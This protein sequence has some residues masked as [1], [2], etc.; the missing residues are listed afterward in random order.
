MM[1]SKQLK[2]YF[3]SF[4]LIL[5]LFFT[6]CIKNNAQNRVQLRAE[7]NQIEGSIFAEWGSSQSSLKKSSLN[8]CTGQ[9]VVLFILD[10]KGEKTD[11]ISKTSLQNDG[12]FLFKNIKFTPRDL[13]SEKKYLLEFNCGSNR[14]VRFVTGKKQQNLSQGTALLSWLFQTNLS[15]DKLISQDAKT[16]ASLYKPLEEIINFSEAYS[17]LNSD[18]SLKAGFEKHFG[19]QPK[20]L[21]DAIPEIQNIKVPEAL[22]EEETSI[23]SVQAFHWSP[24]Y[25]FGYEWRI[26]SVTL[27]NSANFSFSPGANSQGS[28][29]IHLYAGK[30]NGNGG[31]DFSKPYWYKAFPVNINNTIPPSSP[32]VSRVSQEFTSSPTFTVKLDTGSVVDNLPYNCRSFSNFAIVEEAFPGFAGPPLLSSEYK[33]SCTSANFQNITYTLSGQEGKRVLRFWAR[34][35][36]GNIAQTSQNISFVFDL[37]APVLTLLGLNDSAYAGGDT[38]A[39]SWSTTEVNVAPNSATLEYSINNGT[40]WSAI[41][42]SL[43]NSGSFH[44]TLPITNVSQAKVRVRMTDLAGNTGTQESS[45]SFA[46]DTTPPTPPSVSLSSS[47]ISNSNTVTLSVVCVADFAGIF[48][49]TSSSKPLATDL[50][51]QACTTSTNTTVSSPDGV[52]NIYIFSKDLA[53]LVSNSSTISMTLDTTKPSITLSSMNA[54]SAFKGGTAQSISWSASDVNWGSQ[55]VTLSYSIDAGSTYQIIASGISNSGSYLWTLPS[56]NSSQVKVKTSG[57]DVAGNCSSAES[58]SS[59]TIDSTPPTISKLILNNN[60]SMT[61]QNSVLTEINT[62]DNFKVTHFCLTQSITTPSLSDTCWVPV[63]APLPGKIPAP[64]V[65]FANFYYQL[66]LSKGTYDIKGWTRDEAGNISSNSGI[67][68]VDRYSIVY[69][70][71]APPSLTKAYVANK[72]IPTFPISAPDSTVTSGSSIYIKWNANDTEGL[73]DKPISIQY[74]TNEVTFIPISGATDINNSQ[75]GTCTVD[76]GYTGCIVLPSPSSSYFVIRIIVK[77][78]SGLN[79]AI[80]VNAM[81][82]STIRILAGN[83]DSGLDGSASSAIFN[84]YVTN[85]NGAYVAKNKLVISDD[86]KIFYIDPL[87]GLLWIDPMTGLLKKF[88]ESTGTSSG[89]GGPATS[90]TLSSPK[91]IILDYLNRLIIL[92]SNRFRRVN[93]TDMTISTIIGGGTTANP[94]AEIPANQLQIT[95]TFNN[96][97]STIIPLPNGNIIFSV[98]GDLTY[99]IYRDT[100]QKVSKFVVSGTGVTGNPTGSWAGKTPG[101]LG[102]KFN[103]TTSVID[104]MAQSIYWSFTG[105]SYYVHAR[106]NTGTYLAEAPYDLPFNINT[107]VVGMDGNLFSAL[108]FGTSLSKYNPTTNTKTLILGNGV[109]TFEPCNDGTLATSCPVSIS[110]T[111]VSKSGRIYFNDKGLIRTI[112]DAGKILTLFGQFASGGDGGLASS[113]RFGGI[114]DIKFGM[115]NQ[116]YDKLIVLDLNSSTFR[117]LQIGGNINK[118][119]SISSGWDGPYRF[120]TDPATGDIFNNDAYALKKFNRSTSS[121]QTVVGGGATNYFD[122]LA[123]GMVGSAVSISNYKLSILGFINNKLFRMLRYWN[124]TVMTNVMIKSYDTVDNFKQSHFAGDSSANLNSVD[125]SGL[126]YTQDPTDNV[127]KY[128][129]NPDS[130]SKI[131]A[132][133]SYSSGAIYASLP[134]SFY[135]FT[136]RSEANGINFYYCATNGLLYKY[137]KSTNTETPLTWASPT[138]KCLATAKSILW[139][140]ARSSL[141]FTVERNGL[142]G[143]AEY[144]LP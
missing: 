30:N 106:V 80:T 40:S 101:D 1:K 82:Q 47:L 90:A 66:G 67:I 69:D 61:T 73:V 117:E 63:D 141:I 29:V 17:K 115:T 129:W 45:H 32:S 62:S 100:D 41:A 49:S 55:N 125:F 133:T 118:L 60:I 3:N 121:W 113:A 99:Y 13:E 4:L 83:T 95:G 7:A 142:N 91:G 8:N 24:N 74:S 48:I 108:R 120:E 58:A 20:I 116:N 137:T 103:P 51:W 81:N 2:I 39:L 31:V 37:T 28:F 92:D 140:P 87:R 77:D 11:L 36:S 126:L 21:L 93:L 64:S 107:F 104:F 22:R 139:N 76:T 119:T 34:D 9:D 6:S 98:P 96:S 75:N 18:Q 97:S 72:D 143:I 54:N 70:S 26:N 23:L 46:I 56:I 14:Y 123:D 122:G 44:W 50:G 79:T 19:A 42:S 102:I 57:C 127:Y 144:P 53:G 43:P 128:F 138:L 105:D 33:Y 94:S 84:R 124:G 52:K 16:W 135:A 65:S 27:S 12:K 89:D 25:D 10:S 88:I 85:A 136:I 86:G 134:R 59:F 111:F 112:D 38:V 109:A 110:A 132:G 35:A 78:T 130:T 15:T 71:G 131:Y 114:R 5:V 68:S